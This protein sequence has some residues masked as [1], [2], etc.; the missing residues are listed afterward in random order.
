LLQS[1]TF[2]LEASINKEVSS[3]HPLTLGLNKV[4]GERWKTNQAFK[5]AGG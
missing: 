3:A 1:T 5:N 4:K 2:I